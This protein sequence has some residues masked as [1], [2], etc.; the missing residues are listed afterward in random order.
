[1]CTVQVGILVQSNNLG[2]YKLKI[3]TGMIAWRLWRDEKAIRDLGIARVGSSYATV[4][5]KIKNLSRVDQ[6]ESQRAIRTIVESA[7]LYT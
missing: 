6:I 3:T 1:M 5:S 2:I 7:A 4:S